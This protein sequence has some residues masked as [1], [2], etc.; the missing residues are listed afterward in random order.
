MLTVAEWI[1]IKVHVCSA[2]LGHN[3][4]MHNEIQCQY[5]IVCKL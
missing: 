5:L 4:L 3:S 2:S 1:L